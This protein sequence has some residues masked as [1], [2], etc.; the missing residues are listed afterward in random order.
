MNNERLLLVLV[1]SLAVAKTGVELALMDV[2]VLDAAEVVEVFELTGAEIKI[3]SCA[4]G[5]HPMP[6]LYPGLTPLGGETLFPVA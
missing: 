6:E 3:S 4:P 1:I 2:V 5:A